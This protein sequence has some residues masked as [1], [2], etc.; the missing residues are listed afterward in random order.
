VTCLLRIQYSPLD[1]RSKVFLDNL[2]I[3]LVISRLEFL[4][5]SVTQIPQT[6]LARG[7]EK[8]IL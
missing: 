1:Q 8:F 7:L 6:T 2:L 3:V 5:F 4:C